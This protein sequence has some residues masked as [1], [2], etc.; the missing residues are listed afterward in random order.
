MADSPYCL[1]DP[2]V[3]PAGE[4][5]PAE[6]DQPNPPRESGRDPGHATRIDTLFREH[7]DALLRFLSAR[8]GSY[9][10]AQEVAQEAYVR[11]LRLDRPG[12]VSFLK[13]LLYK[14]ASNLAIDRL[15]HRH[16][17]T[18]H[19]RATADAGDLFESSADATSAAMDD[20]RVIANALDELPPH[21]RS[22]FLMSRVEALDSLEI[23]QR[24]GVTDR[25]VRK[26][27]ARALVFLQLRLQHAHTPR[28][29]DSSGRTQENTRD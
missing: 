17:V 9:Q 6:P 23:A 28:S 13:A 2:K 20:V 4:A 14:T 29:R 8:L 26:Y 15:R 19:E 21:C 7:N 12:A 24:L 22:A 3:L 11:L 16:L 25:A 18:R 10:D 1:V 5:A 27:I